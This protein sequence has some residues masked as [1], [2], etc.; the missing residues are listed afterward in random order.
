MLSARVLNHLP[1]RVRNRVEGY[2]DALSV[3]LEVNDPRVLSSIGPA[4]VRGTILR[5]GKQGHPTE[6]PARHSA[7]FDWTYPHDF[8]EMQELYER[9][10]RAQWN[11]NDLP[12][13]TSVD[14]FDPN[15]P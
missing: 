6:M 8:P 10:K 5:R 15:R 7:Y 11:G 2:V 4:A 13:E 12:W 1:S 9:A 14:P 3:L